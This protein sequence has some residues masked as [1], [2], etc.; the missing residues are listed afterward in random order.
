[1]TYYLILFNTFLKHLFYF[2]FQNNVTNYSTCQ[3]VNSHTMLDSK[4]LM[5]SHSF[6]SKNEI[7]RE[8]VDNPDRVVSL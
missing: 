3:D 4:E 6:I 5:S 1:M 7:E 2:T 8:D